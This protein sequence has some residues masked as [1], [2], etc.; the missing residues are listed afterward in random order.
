MF[1]AVI[2]LQQGQVR[3]HETFPPGVI[4]FPEQLR[5]SSPLESH[6]LAQLSS[7]TMEIEV[8]GRLK[9]EMEADCDRCLERAAFA[10]DTDFVLVYR[11]TALA[12]ER[13]IELT[14]VQEREIGFYNGEGI[15]LADVLREQIIL[16]LPMQKVCRD[17]CKGICPM[18]GQNRNTSECG[19]HA[20]LRDDRWAGLREM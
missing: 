13:E 3:F 12:P 11:P 17:D 5:Q 7:A 4:E 20:E 10:I 8:K 16:C 2:D 18:C 19:C 1:L 6:G 15:Q 9:V 14:D